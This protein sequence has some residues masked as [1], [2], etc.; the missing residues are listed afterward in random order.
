M[1]EQSEESTQLIYFA[2]QANLWSL[3]PEAQKVHDYYQSTFDIWLESFEAFMLASLDYED[4]EE[5]WT[6]EELERIYKVNNIF[7]GN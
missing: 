7:T 2:S 5:V 1:L 3:L 6:L 4:P